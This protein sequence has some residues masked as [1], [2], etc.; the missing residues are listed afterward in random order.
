M[1][2]ATVIPLHPDR[3]ARGAGSGGPASGAAPFPAA[4]AKPD[5]VAAWSGVRRLLAVRVDNLGD[6]LMTTPALAAATASVPGLEV[7]LLG[8]PGAVH[9][10]PHL[11]GVSE[12]ITARVPWVRHEG[13]DRVDDDL[14]LVEQLRARRFD[15]A[16][17]FTVCTQSALPAAMLCRLAGIPLRLAHS[18]ENPYQLLTHWVPERD[19]DVS[20]ARHEVRRQLDLVA[21]VG[22]RVADERL[23]F[24]LRQADVDAV[25][26]RLA[27]L[28]PTT[29]PPSPAAVPAPAAPRAAREHAPLVVVHVG[30]SAPSRRW[31]AE[32]FGAA[33]GALV[34]ATGAHVVFTGS[35]DE[36]PLVEEARARMRWPSRSLAGQLSIGELGALLARA[37]LLVSNNSGPVHLAA[38]VGT[39]VVDLYALTNPQHTPW[40]VPSRVLNHDVPCRDCLKSRCPLGHHACL[41]GV[42]PSAATQAALELLGPTGGKGATI[43]DHPSLE[44]RS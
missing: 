20:T 30:A 33:A 43:L 34:R 39:P 44:A 41:L 24:Q 23:R 1:S 12:V 25:D 5:D 19:V 29:L 4:S 7:T 37:R 17:I 22:W 32:R 2:L 40:H 8:G 10:A 38:A 6:V 11:P 18:R 3:A 27:G 35:T 13:D 16:V 15:A 42:P 26:G 9:L 14:A 36:I 28:F 31:P 21:H